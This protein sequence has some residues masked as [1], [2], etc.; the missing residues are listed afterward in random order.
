MEYRILTTITDV[1]PTRNF[2]PRQSYNWKEDDQMNSVV[3]MHSPTKC[4]IDISYDMWHF[5]AYPTFDDEFL[6]QTV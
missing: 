6:I 5:S 2:H 3:K 4:D 1:L